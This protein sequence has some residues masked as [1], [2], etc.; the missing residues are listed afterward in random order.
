MRGY[1][2]L[3]DRERK[4]IAFTQANCSQGDSDLLDLKE[5]SKNIKTTES[6]YQIFNAFSNT[7]SSNYISLLNYPFEFYFKNGGGSGRGRE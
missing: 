1:D 3:F 4:K 6:D 5:S 2:I 7:S